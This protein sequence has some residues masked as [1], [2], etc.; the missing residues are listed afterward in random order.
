MS[1]AS[2]LH[3][4]H[5]GTDM[6]SLPV[7]VGVI[8]LIATGAA[9]A[10]KIKSLIPSD[11]VRALSDGEV[12]VSE[13]NYKAGKTL[14]IPYGGMV[15]VSFE[16]AA[17]EFKRPIDD[18]PRCSVGTSGFDITNTTF[19]KFSADVPV[20]AWGLLSLS[21][22]WGYDADNKQVRVH[23]K[24]FRVGYDIAN[25]ADKPRIIRNR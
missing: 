5:K 12:T 18:L 8:L 17:D 9:F 21:C 11:T 24:N 16:A 20:A 13:Q 15:R 19:K 22:G 23:F 6:K 14:Q 2:T 10:D 25:V 4:I 3:N 1:G 7:A